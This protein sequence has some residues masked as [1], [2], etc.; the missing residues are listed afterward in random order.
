[1]FNTVLNAIAYRLFTCEVLVADDGL[2]IPPIQSTGCFLRQK[3]KYLCFQFPRPY[4]DYRADPRT[5]F[6]KNKKYQKKKK[7]FQKNIF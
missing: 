6:P 4:L 5:F 2:S 3:K 1:M 7:V